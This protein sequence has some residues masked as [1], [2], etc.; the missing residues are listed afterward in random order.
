MNLD[1]AQKN[2]NHQYEMV[3]RANAHIANALTHFN[4]QQARVETEYH[5]VLK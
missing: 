5:K 3:S 1:H 2:Q 4:Q